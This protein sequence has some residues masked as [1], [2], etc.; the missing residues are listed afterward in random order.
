MCSQTSPVPT[1]DLSTSDTELSKVVEQPIKLGDPQ[2]Q[3]NDYDPVQNGLDLSLHRNE[4]VHN[5]ENKSDRDSR[6]DNGS[7]RHS[8][9]SK[10]VAC[11]GFA[12]A[13]MGRLW[14]LFLARNVDARTAS[15]LDS[16]RVTTR[17]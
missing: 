4:P 13:N 8:I 7:E 12:P 5:P 2:N 10:S 17:S 15:Q 3:N 14:L 6:E 9:Y 16:H 1:P 11:N